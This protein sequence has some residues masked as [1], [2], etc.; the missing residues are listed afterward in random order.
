V[1]PLAA[2]LE[3]VGKSKKKVVAQLSA[4]WDVTKDIKKVTRAK[5]R[6]FCAR[7]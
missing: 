1:F 5:V 6:N 7:I 2:K 4:K 3:N